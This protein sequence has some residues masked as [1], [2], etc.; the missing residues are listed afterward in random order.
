MEIIMSIKVC[1]IPRVNI[2]YKE[3]DRRKA[4]L[5][6]PKH[7]YCIPQCEEHDYSANDKKNE[8]YYGYPSFL[9]R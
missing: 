4:F 8:D 6:K 1:P 9:T 2:N 3:N 7:Q 5:A